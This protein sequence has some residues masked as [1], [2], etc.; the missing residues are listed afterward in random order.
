MPSLQGGTTLDPVSGKSAGGES[1]HRPPLRRQPAMQ[2]TSPATSG[3]TSRADPGA[4]SYSSVTIQRGSAHLPKS[5]MGYV[6]FIA[7]TSCP[8]S[9]CGRMRAWL[10]GRPWVEWRR[11]AHGSAPVHALSVF[12]PVPFTQH[13]FSSAPESALALALRRFL[14]Y[15]QCFACMRIPVRSPYAGGFWMAPPL[16]RGPLVAFA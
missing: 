3:G 14:A 10:S 7:T 1:K 16:D 13:C 8:Q 15:I 6:P 5:V 12:A 4:V 11:L 9:R 2:Y